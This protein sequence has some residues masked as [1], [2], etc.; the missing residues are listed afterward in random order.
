MVEKSRTK[1]IFHKTNLPLTTTTVIRTGSEKSR[2]RIR[3]YLNKRGKMKEIISNTIERICGNVPED[4]VLRDE[5][6]SRHTSF[7]IG[8]PAA[9]IVKI[10]VG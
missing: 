4:R 6:M 10:R 7:R 1:K 5:P 8:G 3:I 9:A 2:T